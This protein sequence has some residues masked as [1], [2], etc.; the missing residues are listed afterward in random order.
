MYYC[1]KRQ[2]HLKIL[3]I[4]ALNTVKKLTK[5]LKKYAVNPNISKKFKIKERQGEQYQGHLI[6]PVQLPEHL[7]YLHV[8]QNTVRKLFFTW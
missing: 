6:K 7:I 2:G 3:A 8:K 5:K 4:K 1:Y